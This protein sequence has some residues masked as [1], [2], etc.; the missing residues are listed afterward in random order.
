[1]TMT[2]PCQFGRKSWNIPNQMGAAT[3]LAREALEWAEAF[4]ISDQSKYSVRLALEEMLTNTVKYGYEDQSE[5]LISVQITADSEVIRIEMDDDAR[6]FD[7]TGQ[8]QAD[9]Q[10]RLE[11]DEEGGFGIELVRR[12]CKTIGYRR[13]GDHNRLTM[14][15]AILDPDDNDSDSPPSFME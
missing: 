15:I 11:E 10:Q 4:P 9:I 3:A 14:Q 1:M 12:I 13:E 6:P 7:P 5:H 8:T 2:T